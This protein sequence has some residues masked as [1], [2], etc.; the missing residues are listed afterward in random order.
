MKY[1]KEV[2]FILSIFMSI[3]SGMAEAT[4]LYPGETYFSNSSGYCIDVYRQDGLLFSNGAKHI[5]INDGSS[6]IIPK[7]HPN[8]VKVDLYKETHKDATG[9][10][11][12]C[13]G[14]F[15]KRIKTLKIAN[16]FEGLDGP[17]H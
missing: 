13:Y 15:Y 7:K 3:F 6:Y 9:P 1:V 12:H 16:N 4:D 5:Y 11:G 14:A 8:Y 10:G 17:N 2:V